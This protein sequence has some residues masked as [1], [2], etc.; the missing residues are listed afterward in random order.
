MHHLHE[1]LTEAEQKVAERKITGLF[2]LSLVGVIG[3]VVSYIVGEAEFGESGFAWFT[4]GDQTAGAPDP[5]RDDEV[6]IKL[7][8]IEE[9]QSRWPASVAAAITHW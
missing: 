2:L 6:D 4:L 7:M 3:F 9:S 8:P 1:P 5:T